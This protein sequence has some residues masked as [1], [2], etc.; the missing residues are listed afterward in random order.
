MD[1][2]TNIPDV[3]EDQPPQNQL[4]AVFEDHPP[5]DEPTTVIEDLPPQNRVI[6]DL[7]PQNIH[8]NCH[9]DDSSISSESHSLPSQ[10]TLRQQY[11]EQGQL[12]PYLNY[13]IQHVI[14][15]SSTS[16][17][18]HQNEVETILDLVTMTRGEIESITAVVQGRETMISK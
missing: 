1:V 15:L 11:T 14:C 8:H 10:H 7:P 18:Y 4:P 9:N 6:G 5:Q 17:M 12:D 16:I 3:P 13:V 2:P